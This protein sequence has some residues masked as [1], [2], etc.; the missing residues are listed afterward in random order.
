MRTENLV[1]VSLPPDVACRVQ[2]DLQCVYR[3][4]LTDRNNSRSPETYDYGLRQVGEAVVAF[5]VAR[6][7]WAAS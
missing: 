2:V 5:D 7:E 1:S 6:R 4:L 3:G